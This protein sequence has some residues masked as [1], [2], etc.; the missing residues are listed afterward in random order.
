MARWFSDD[1][2][3]GCCQSCSSSLLSTS[4]LCL[5]F[6]ANRWLLPRVEK[7]NKHSR[8][9]L[10]EGKGSCA[11]HLEHMPGRNVIGA[12]NT[13][14]QTTNLIDGM[15]SAASALFFLRE[16]TRARARDYDGC[17][18]RHNQLP[19]SA[20]G[21]LNRFFLFVRIWDVSSQGLKP[22]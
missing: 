19:T 4:V 12:S 9:E 8:I 2:L 3:L 5:S 7:S 10:Q 11:A 14:A 15:G 1:V 13:D 22:R 16:R 21:S 6:C 20:L 17:L 18:K